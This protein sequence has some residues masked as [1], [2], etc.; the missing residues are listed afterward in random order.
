MW[1]DILLKT[2][3]YPYC[4]KCQY[5]KDKNLSLANKDFCKKCNAKTETGYSKNEKRVY[6][7]LSQR[8]LDSRKKLGSLKEFDD[9]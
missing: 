9:T 4:K 8:E 2:V 7:P 5:A 1:T 6:V 3:W